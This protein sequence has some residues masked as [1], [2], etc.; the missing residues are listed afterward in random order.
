MS[1]LRSANSLHDS[2]S[3]R[4]NPIDAAKRESSAEDLSPGALFAKPQNSENRRHDR[5]NIREG[6]QLR[7]LQIAQQP[8]VKDVG[9][10]G[11]EAGHVQH[12][13]PSSPCEGATVW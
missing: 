8:E 3:A 2:G 10:R 4:L 6:A 7:G 9:H 12:G 13:S 5:Q 1:S 11:A